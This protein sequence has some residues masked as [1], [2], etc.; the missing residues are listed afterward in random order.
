MIDLNLIN[1][2][3]SQY[4]KIIVILKIYIKIRA[5]HIIS[6]NN[7]DKLQIGCI[8]HVKSHHAKKCYITRLVNKN[9]LFNRI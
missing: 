8:H 3:Q 9:Q 7:V 2:I 1:Q 6:Q 5:T 4:K